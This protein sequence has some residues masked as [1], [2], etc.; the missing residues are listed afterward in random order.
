MKNKIEKI[1][2]LDL[3]QFGQIWL[4]VRKSGNESIELFANKNLLGFEIYKNRNP[5]YLV[6][7]LE[8]LY[9]FIICG[10]KNNGDVLIM[11]HLKRF[12]VTNFEF[13]YR[14]TLKI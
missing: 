14:K 6:I 13:G 5:F 2:D 4:N 12:Q 11:K 1:Q 3:P 9:A 8:K 7:I 10:K